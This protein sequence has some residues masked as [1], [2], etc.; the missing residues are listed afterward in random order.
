MEFAR[1]V[2]PRPSSLLLCPINMRRMMT[3]NL[4]AA[5]G[6]MF[7]G[8]KPD[9]QKELSLCFGD[10]CKVYDGKTTN[11]AYQGKGRKR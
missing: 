10:Y 2:G 8:L 5:P 4:N 11:Y 7:T 1:D 6:V 3:F 9:F